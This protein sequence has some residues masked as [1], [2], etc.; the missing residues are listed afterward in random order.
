MEPGSAEVGAGT[1]GQHQNKWEEEVLPRDGWTLGWG[2]EGSLSSEIFRNW[3]Y[4]DLYHT[5][6]IRYSPCSE[7][8]L[9]LK[10]S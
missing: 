9:G 5:V 6:R 2:L 4:R 1:G 10:S 3:R 8:E 7:Q